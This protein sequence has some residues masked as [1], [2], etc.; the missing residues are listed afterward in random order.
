[1]STTPSP[2]SHDH[3]LGIDAPAR[4]IDSQGRV[5]YRASAYGRCPRALVAAARGE[6]AQPW[7]EWFQ[8][9]LQE[10]KDFEAQI[11]NAWEA[12]HSAV[13]AEQQKMCELEV[14][15]NVF[16]RG[17]IDGMTLDGITNVLVE[18]KKFRDSGWDDFLTRGVEVRPEYPW[19]VAFYM[20]AL[21]LDDCYMIGGHLDKNGELVEVVSKTLSMPPLPLKAIVKRVREIERMIGIGLAAKEVKC[22][23]DYPCPYYMLHDEPVDPETGEPVSADDAVFIVPKEHSAAWSKIVSDFSAVDEV[24]KVLKAKVGERA[25][26]KE[27]FAEQARTMLNEM[28]ADKAKEVHGRVGAKLVVK[29]VRYDR[30]AYEVKATTIDYFKVEDKHKKADKERETE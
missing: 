2:D 20:H 8:A 21:D 13:V 14:M 28:G 3:P 7:P 19:Q 12:E 6:E 10:G 22:T 11:I 17:S 9:V 15:D 29:R 5:I 18:I 25:A 1:M 23:G 4:Y 16:I 30:K 27:K 26:Q 24:L